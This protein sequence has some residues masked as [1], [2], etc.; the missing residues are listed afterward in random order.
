MIIYNYLNSF[1]YKS[2]FT[3][4][5]I[6][7]GLKFPRV[8]WKPYLATAKSRTPT[9]QLSKMKPSL[10]LIGYEKKNSELEVALKHNFDYPYGKY[11]DLFYFKE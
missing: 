8:Q 10:P 11:N 9:F 1:V 7:T 4:S 2:Y 6:C 3:I 5:C